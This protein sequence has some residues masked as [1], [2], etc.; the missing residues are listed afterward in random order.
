MFLNIQFLALPLKNYSYK[1]VTSALNSKART[2]L[3]RGKLYISKTSPLCVL[4]A[5][6]SQFEKDLFLF[7]KSRS[8]EMV[9]GG[10]M[11][12]SF[13]GR[14]SVDTS[15]DESCY[16]WELLARALMSMALEV[17]VRL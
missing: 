6:L 11:V 13:M 1:Q 3:K 10:R 14:R 17:L 7:L 9:H 12:L 8:E 4:D 5:Y 15:A 16:Q 2:P